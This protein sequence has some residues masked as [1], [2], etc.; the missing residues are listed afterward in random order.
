LGECRS[1]GQTRERVV[2]R[3]V[4]YLRL[5]TPSLGDVLVRGYSSST[6]QRP[7]CDG[8][9][10]AISR[11]HGPVDGLALRNLLQSGRNVLLGVPGK[12]SSCEV[13]AQKVAKRPAGLCDLRR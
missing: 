4:R 11:L 9:G 10:T 1:V 6:R 12:D 13:L 2:M 3:Q 7:I 8:D 5:R